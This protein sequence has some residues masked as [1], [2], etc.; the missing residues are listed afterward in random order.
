MKRICLAL[1]C[2]GAFFLQANAQTAARYDM[3]T[4]TTTP[5]QVPFGALPNLLV[6]PNAVVAI[7][8]FPATANGSTLPPNAGIMCTN[9]IA[10]YT[11]S[12]LG[13]ACSP[14]AQIT[15]PGSSVCM[16][17]SG[18]Q[19]VLGFWYDAATQTHMTYTVKTAWGTF[20]PYEIDPPAARG[21]SMTWPATPG[22]AVY[23]GASAWGTSLTAPTSPLVGTTDTQ[24]LTNKTLDGVT[25]ATMAFVDPSSSI[26]TQLNGKQASLGYTPL[27][28][29]N[30]LSDVASASTALSNLGAQPAL[31]FTAV[32]NTRTVN[33]HAL[34]A[35]ITV[36]ASDVGLGNVT[37]DAQ[38]KASIVP[39]TVPSA[40]QVCVGNAGGTACAQV[41][42]SGDCTLAASG[43]LSCTK[44]GGVAFGSAAFSSTSAFDAAGAATTAQTNAEAYASNANNISGGTVA[45]ARLPA[46]LAS[47][48]SIN[49]TSIPASATLTQTIASGT[50]S[51]GAS[52]IASNA[53]ATVVT[54]TATGVLTTDNISADFNADPTSTLGY[55]PG[56]ML[57]IVKYPT[58]GHV[59]FKV[60]NNTSSSI[61]PGA[62]TLNWRVVR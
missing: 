10:T 57:T 6:V 23:G 45:A 51:L 1:A 39:N 18:T 52:A 4:L 46:A 15:A 22:I 50:A 47:S 53:C 54:V 27:N 11:D 29:A 14:T 43:A 60:C 37:N 26:Q 9:K 8:G 28:P 44:S 55:E 21:G 48:T 24:T 62:T 32:P 41:S 3:P 38:T 19:G 25:P 35:N 16:S 20:G 33:G 2:A 7:C 17:T 12:T 61:T 36:T 5:A 56:A 13:T 31:G 42:I 34:S 58:S 49:S 59:N 40:G 30:N